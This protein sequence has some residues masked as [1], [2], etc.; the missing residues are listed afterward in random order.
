VTQDEKWTLFTDEPRYRKRERIWLALF[1]LLLGVGIW[2]WPRISLRILSWRLVSGVNE[3]KALNDLADRGPDSLP[4]LEAHIDDPDPEVRY[5]IVLCLKAMKRKE[6]LPLV[7]RFLRDP[8]VDVRVNA[9]DAMA[10]QGNRKVIPDLIRA[11]EDEDL[12][13]RRVAG[14]SLYYITGKEFGYHAHAEAEARQEAISRWRDWWETEGA[15]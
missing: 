13:I 9:M 6:A 14:K 4:Y 12:R 8:D 3:W 2:Q 7:E 5:K 10:E 1:V 11:L 15:P